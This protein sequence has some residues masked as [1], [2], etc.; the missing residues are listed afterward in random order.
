MTK[1]D[2][3]AALKKEIKQKERQLYRAEKEMT[4]WNGAKYQPHSNAK[5]S[6]QFIDSS[7]KE[8]SELK[9]KLF[10]LEKGE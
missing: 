6:N 9:S 1:Q 7:R 10:K 5:M 8:I 2:E 3:N 4:S